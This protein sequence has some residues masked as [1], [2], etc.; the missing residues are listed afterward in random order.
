MTASRFHSLAL[1][2][3]WLRPG[4]R[5]PRREVE[6]ASSAGSFAPLAFSARKYRILAIPASSIPFEDAG[7]APVLT[8]R[9]KV[10]RNAEASCVQVGPTSSK[11]FATP[12]DASVGETLAAIPPTNDPRESPAPAPPMEDDKFILV[13]LS[14]C[15][16]LLMRCLV[17]WTGSRF[18]SACSSSVPTKS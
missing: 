5:L 15:R 18:S 11:I 2:S 1:L 6:A 8:V 16:K 3:L 9:A 14:C 4:M 10:W 13:P 7:E 17:W 12:S